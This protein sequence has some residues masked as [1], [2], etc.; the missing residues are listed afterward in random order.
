MFITTT[1]NISWYT[2]IEDFVWLGSENV[3]T[4][5]FGHT[6]ILRFHLAFA[7]SLGWNDGL[8][9]LKSTIKYMI[10]KASIK[11]MS[12]IAHR[13]MID[14][15]KKIQVPR[16]E[17]FPFETGLSSRAAKDRSRPLAQKTP[18]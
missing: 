18:P 17:T 13:E 6:S 2:N 11:L 12:M 3:D 1:K 14:K 8:L 9:F 10:R 16:F 4:R 7:S 15:G 5:I